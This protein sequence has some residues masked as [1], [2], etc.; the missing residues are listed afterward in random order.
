M[1]QSL[2][3]LPETATIHNVGGLDLVIKNH[4]VEQTTLLYWIM[5]TMA[6]ENW[7]EV[8][9]QMEKSGISFEIAVETCVKELDTLN[10]LFADIVWEPLNYTKDW[11]EAFELSKS[12]LGR[13]MAEQYIE[14]IRR[15]DNW[16]D[17]NR[18]MNPKSQFHKQIKNKII[19]EKQTKEDDK[20]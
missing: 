15:C 14:N 20:I 19:I 16:D 6:G 4:E 9:T 5:G 10:T 18:E 1:A 12:I 17:L 3:R 13:K 7:N 11:D 8:V 2:T